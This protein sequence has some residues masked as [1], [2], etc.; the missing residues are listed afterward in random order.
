[1]NT[2]A[3]KKLDSAKALRAWCQD[4]YIY[5]QLDDERRIGVPIRYYP[6]LRYA[7]KEQVANL[8]IRGNGRALR[9]EALDEDIL[10]ADMVAGNFPRKGQAA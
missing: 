1:M 5:I 6:K 4:S 7:D 8:T 2:S 3:A 9:W 10:V